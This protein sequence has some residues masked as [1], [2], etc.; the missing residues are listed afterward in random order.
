MSARFKK[1]PTAGRTASAAPDRAA[2]DRFVAGGPRK[3]TYPWQNP[4]A[5]DDLAKQL[6]VAQP[7]R[8][9]LMVDWLVRET[10][11]TKRDIVE[12]ALR[13]WVMR[14]LKERGLPF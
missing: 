10:G 1:V 8:L 9:M 4:I 13:D 6:N 5:R 12:S 14:E 3:E 7:E 11:K 2:A